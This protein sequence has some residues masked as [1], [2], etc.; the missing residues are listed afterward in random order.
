[1]K[2]INELMDQSIK[3]IQNQ[4]EEIVYLKQELSK[5]SD[6]VNELESLMAKFLSMLLKASEGKNT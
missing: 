6:R 3:K 4:F 5:K 2:N 1:M